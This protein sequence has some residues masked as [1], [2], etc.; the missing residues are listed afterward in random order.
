TSALIKAGRSKVELS[1]MAVTERCQGLGI[2]RR[3][4]LAAIARFKTMG[5][6]QL[7]LESNSKLK[8]ALT[9]YE[10]HGFKHAP[11]P[12]MAS[13]YSRSD[14]YMVYE[15]RG[16]RP[17]RRSVMAGGAKLSVAGGRAKRRKPGAESP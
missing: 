7:F 14:V 1:K 13:H 17:G 6:K 8:P 2:G 4:L 15:P 5:A 12:K 3:L 10:A 16:T 9:L 11:R